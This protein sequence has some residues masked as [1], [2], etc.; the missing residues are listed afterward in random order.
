MIK[1]LHPVAGGLALVVISSFWTS[2]IVSELFAS[3]AVITAV[4]TAIPWG[5][6]I[7]I[8]ALMTAGLSGFLLSKKR[9]GP[10]VESKR[11]RMPLVAA[12]GILILIPSAFY[13]AAKAQAGAFDTAFYTIQAIELAA[14]AVNIYLLGLNMRD[15][16]RLTGKLRQKA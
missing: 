10:I 7:L 11:K 1:I 12:N 5:F 4:K 2:T 15:G 13:L 9:R 3:A 6:L 8:P 14:G 16:L